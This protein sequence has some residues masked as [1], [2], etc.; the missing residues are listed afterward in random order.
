M[1][2]IRRLEQE[3]NALQ[4]QLRQQNAEA[5]AQQ[6]CFKV[7]PQAKRNKEQHEDIVHNQAVYIPQR[8]Q[9][10]AK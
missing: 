6:L 1:D 9:A 2:E 4:T 5:K 7:A 10:K 3:I 8:L